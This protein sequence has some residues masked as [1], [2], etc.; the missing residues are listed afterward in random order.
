MPA[1]LTENGTMKDRRKT[2]VFDEIFGTNSR[3]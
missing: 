1:L 2:Y 3:V